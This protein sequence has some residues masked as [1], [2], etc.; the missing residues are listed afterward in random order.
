MLAALFFRSLC[1][2]ITMNGMNLKISDEKKM[3]FDTI[4]I[5]TRQRELKLHL[6]IAADNT[7][8][9][10]S[11]CSMYTIVHNITHTESAVFYCS[12]QILCLMFQKDS[13]QKFIISP[14]R[15]ERSGSRNNRVR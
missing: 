11:G 15:H 9:I 4:N 6:M 1:T 8:T 5:D 2:I 14:T 3:L 12:Q 10:C 7:T 13:K